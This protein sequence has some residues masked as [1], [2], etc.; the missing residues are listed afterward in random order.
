M[1]GGLRAPA[2]GLAP[3]AA[4]A[5]VTARTQPGPHAVWGARPCAQSF[6]RASTR[7]AAE[8]AAAV[9]AALASRRPLQRRGTACAAAPDTGDFFRPIRDVIGGREADLE[10]RLQ[11]LAKRATAAESAA[12]AKRQEL[13]GK[14]AEFQAEREVQQQERSRL[15]AQVSQLELTLSQE[16]QA[17]GKKLQEVREAGEVRFREAR[18]EIMRLEN[19]MDTAQEGLDEL[20]ASVEQLTSDLERERAARAELGKKVIALQASYSDASDKLETSE[21]RQTVT[22]REKD[23]VTRSLEVAQRQV[24]KL[25]TSLAERTEKLEEAEAKLKSVRAS[26]K[27]AATAFVSKFDRSTQ[28]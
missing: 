24:A 16:Q 25:E 21:G 5:V 4:A 27:S 9:A 17:Q 18:L 8:A 15:Q 20:E 1:N 28:T 19:E 22:E 6:G 14:E 23:R 11:D 3:P 13:L 12:E 7:G 2:T 26:L 10:R